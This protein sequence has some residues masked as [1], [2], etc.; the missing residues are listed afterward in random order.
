M[1]REILH[2]VDDDMGIQEAEGLAVDEFLPEK[3]GHAYFE[4]SADNNKL[5]KIMKENQH[6]SNFLAVMP[7]ELNL[8]I[9]SCH[10]FQNNTSFVMSN[11]K[12]LYSSQNFVVKIVTILFSNSVFLASEN[13][14]SGG[15][16]NHVNINKTF[17]NGIT[18]LGY[19]SAEFERKRKNTLRNTVHRDFVALCGL[20]LGSAA[21]KAKPRNTQSK[22]L[23][24][25][26]LKQAAKDAKRS[27]EITKKDSYRKNFKV[28][29]KYYTLTDQK[30][31][32]HG[33]KTV[34]NF[35]QQSTKQ[36]QH[37]SNNRHGSEILQLEVCILNK[38]LK[39]YI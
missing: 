7:P 18:L 26:N 3:I 36:G 9:E 30:K 15:S 22:Y 32:F 35:N 16:I 27:E 23:L 5:Q 11:E 25:D 1:S 34:Q 37:Y 39:E 29:S 24:G 28:Q 38:N 33:R 10:Q 20:K 2:Q 12:I 19:I 31:P 8:E 4:S 6:P 21:Y 17:M 14:P 13:G